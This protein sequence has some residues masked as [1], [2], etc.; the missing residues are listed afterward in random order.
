MAPPEKADLAGPKDTPLAA[1]QASTYN[2]TEFP[3]A[4]RPLLD[5]VR[6]QTP[7]ERADKM[8]RRKASLRAM[9]AKT[10]PALRRRTYSSLPGSPGTL[11]S[12]FAAGPALE[13]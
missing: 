11:F 13:Q 7:A 4:W 9:L 3:E 10:A 12:S 8:A 2:P 1:A 5:T 6:L